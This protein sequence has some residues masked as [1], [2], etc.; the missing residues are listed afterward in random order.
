MTSSITPDGARAEIAENALKAGNPVKTS[1][2]AE[3]Q[4]SKILVSD[5]ASQLS[6]LGSSSSQNVVFTDGV[7]AVVTP[8]TAVQTDNTDYVFDITAQG[9][10]SLITGSVVYYGGSTFTATGALRVLITDSTG[11]GATTGAYYIPFG[12]LATE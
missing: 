11:I 8:I 3:T 6:S 10:E 4:T 5:T 2:G 1:T 12:V 9:I 7:P